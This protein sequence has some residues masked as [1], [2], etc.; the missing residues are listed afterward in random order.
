MSAPL[1]TVLVVIVNYRTARLVVECLRSLAPEVASHGGARVVVVDNDSGD[2][3]VEVLREAVVAGGWSDWAEVLASDRNGG[4]AY[5]NNLAMRRALAG[6]TK[7]DLF[8]LLNP[9]TLVHPHALVTL[10]EFLRDNPHVG[11]CGCAIKEGDGTPWPYA[12]R[13][14]SIAGEIEN[15]FAFGP[16]TRL[17]SR[18][19][20]LREMGGVPTRVDW[21][22]GCSMMIR[23]KVVQAIG[24]MDEGYFL[25]YEET[26]YCLQAK[27]NGIECWYLPQSTIVHI[28]GQSTG[29]TARV[30]RPA[31]VPDY[32]FDSRRRFFV[33]N[34]GR[35]YAIGADL[36][37][38][39]SHILG[40]FRKWLQRAPS[41]FPPGL[42]GDY[43]RHSAL[44]GRNR[45]ESTRRT[46][47]ADRA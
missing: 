26:D 45:A 18:W 10:V 4:F 40:R 36:A 43:W 30:N 5:G 8:W 19:R 13:F 6:S 24:P 33:K 34:Y 20:V 17:L 28:A 46:S 7:P 11:I 12:F 2:G 37:W 1:P 39:G 35:L 44:W 32:W 14:P 22:S 38:M 16:I 3:S 29:V 9:D 25:Y 23:S 47:S 15:G 41:A 27:R 31:R 21:I 42:L